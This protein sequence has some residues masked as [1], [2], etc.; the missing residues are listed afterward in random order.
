MPN[1]YDLKSENVVIGTAAANTSLGIGRVP[2]GKQRFV[3]FVKATNL[4]IGAGGTNTLYMASHTASQ[5]AN[6]PLATAAKKM[7]I[8]FRVDGEKQT[9]QVPEGE[10][11]MNNPLF[12]IA[13]SNFLAARTSRASV[14]L[15]IQYY[16][17]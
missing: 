7:T 10:P 12:A 3:T 5:L 16:D 9:E 1:I 15:F 2:A 8:P 4:H 6:L 17:E 14:D 11:D 13:A